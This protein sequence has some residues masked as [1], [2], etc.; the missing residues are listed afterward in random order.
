MNYC[1][2]YGNSTNFYCA[3]G[4]VPSGE[5]DSVMHDRIRD[6]DFSEP[7][8]PGIE[9][10]LYADRHAVRHTLCRFMRDDLCKCPDAQE[11]LAAPPP[12]P[13]SEEE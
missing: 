2:P 9:A 13:E 10:R 8:Q 1:E 12:P 3:A 5:P 6:C 11:A 7:E 4:G